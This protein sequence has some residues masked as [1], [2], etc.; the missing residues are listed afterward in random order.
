MRLPPALL[1]TLPLLAWRRSIAPL[2][3]AGAAAVGRSLGDRVATVATASLAGAAETSSPASKGGK[4]GVATPRYLWPTPTLAWGIVLVTS[5]ATK[6]NPLQP[7]FTSYA[8]CL[9]VW[10]YLSYTAVN[11]TTQPAAQ[12]G[13][14]AV[15]HREFASNVWRAK[16]RAPRST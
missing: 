8:V 3:V 7:G 16:L 1:A 12:T 11:A 2:V 9:T 5:L 6:W 15:R 14:L 4:G 10:G 13:Q